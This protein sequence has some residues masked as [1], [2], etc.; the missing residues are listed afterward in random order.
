MQFVLYLLGFWAM[1]I[2]AAVAFRWGAEPDHGRMRWLTGF[3]VGNAIAIA[4]I[5]ILMLL[6]QQA[7]VN[8]AYGIG[9]GGAFLLAQLSISY[10]FRSRLRPLQYGGLV[11]MTTG[12]LLLGLG[13]AP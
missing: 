4:S 11:A 10:V 7:N 8:V 3:L 12:M 6:F 1:Q 13:G 2:V 5:W 9:V